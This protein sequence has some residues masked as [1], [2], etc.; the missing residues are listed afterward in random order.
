MTSAENFTKIICEVKNMK[1]IDTT[2]KRD[3]LLVSFLLQHRGRENCVSSKKISRYLN[4]N[5]CPTHSDAVHVIIRRIMFE[6]TL[7]ICHVNGK[8][9]FWAETTEEIQASINDMQSRIDQ[10]Q[11]RIEHLQHFI[12][13]H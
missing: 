10:M 6:R 1:A 5:G 12:M 9:Y 3:N 13:L 4:E 7:P 2:F 8:G 11:L